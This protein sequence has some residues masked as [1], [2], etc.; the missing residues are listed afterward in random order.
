MAGGALRDPMDFV[1]VDERRNV[2]HMMA[3]RAKCVG[4]DNHIT[5]MGPVI[6]RMGKKGRQIYVI[7]VTDRTG[8]SPAQGMLASIAD[9]IGDAADRYARCVAVGQGM[10]ICIVTV[11]TVV[12]MD[13][14]HHISIARL[15]MASLASGADFS[16]AVVVRIDMIEKVIAM[17]GRAVAAV[18]RHSNGLAVSGLQRTVIVVTSQAIVVNLVVY[19]AYRQAGCTACGG[20]MTRRATGIDCHCGR[21][22]GGKL[23][24]GIGMTLGAI[25]GSS[26]AANR[27]VMDKGAGK[28]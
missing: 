28:L 21:V 17:A 2:C 24:C 26:I 13:I 10:S 8:R 3:I 5:G 19:D 11:K 16:Q 12:G 18:G 14:G 23:P 27:V 7:D 4:P 6:A 15:I 9:H 22:V 1:T 25:P 20:G